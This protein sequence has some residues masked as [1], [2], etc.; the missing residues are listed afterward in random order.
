MCERWR[1][2]YLNCYLVELLSH[3]RLECSCNPTS[4]LKYSSSLY[5]NCNACRESVMF[6]SLCP[7]IVSTIALAHHHPPLPPPP[8][9]QS[10]HRQP[11]QRSNYQAC[12]I[13]DHRHLCG[14]AMTTGRAGLSVVAVR[15]KACSSCQR[16]GHNL[17]VV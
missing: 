11:L 15:T 6:D 4:A 1:M 14:T 5:V 8:R 2:I 10:R 12:P 13:L 16:C 7:G 3:P 17:P 9:F